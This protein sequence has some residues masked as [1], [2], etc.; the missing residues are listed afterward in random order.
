MSVTTTHKNRI[1]EADEDS[2][3]PKQLINVERLPAEQAVSKLIEHA[4]DL[5]ASDVFFCSFEQHTAIQVRHL[6]IIRPIAIVTPEEGKRMVAHIRHSSGADVQDKRHPSDGRWIFRGE[7]DAGVDLRINF[8]PTLHGDDVA[9]RLLIRGNELFSLD[10]LG[11]EESQLTSFKQM[12]ETPAGLVLITGPTGSGKTATLYASL[13]H[14]HDGQHKINTIEDPV[15]YAVDGIHQSQINTAIDLGFAEVLRAIM[16]QNPDIIMIGEVRDEETA[17]IAVRAANSG[18]LVLATL[19]APDAALA[20]QAMRAFGV[21]NHFLG[22]CLRG[23]VS[24]RLV[25]TL[26]PESR[27]KFDLSDAPHTFDE[28]REYLE[29][30]DGGALYAPGPRESNQFTGYS[31]R[32]GVFE[33]MTITR[34]I[35]NAIIEGKSADAVREQL[36]ADK[37]LQFRQAALL[38]V[39][40]GVTSTEELFRV[41]PTEQLLVD[42]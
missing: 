32:T 37:M 14:L 1:V 27:I 18:I 22:T 4:V 9:I 40:R 33:V 3:A 6:G 34:G 8:L 15:E 35:R 29:P 2:S 11:M 5:G 20:I 21:P 17:K 13:L 24:Q 28:V 38:K 19:H 7:T 31:S 12:I 23:V 25:R 16:R 39:A 36:R 26:D 30:T 42:V 41:I 10:D